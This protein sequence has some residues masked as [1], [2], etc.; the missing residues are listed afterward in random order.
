[1]AE[2]EE[3]VEWEMGEEEGREREEGFASEKW[4]T[5]LRGTGGRWPRGCEPSGTTA[6][7]SPQDGSLDKPPWPWGGRV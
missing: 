2:G 3:G 6:L 5:A 4:K 7:P 1:M